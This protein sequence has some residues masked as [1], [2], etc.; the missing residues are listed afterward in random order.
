MLSVRFRACL[1]SSAKSLNLSRKRYDLSD[2]WM[3]DDFFFRTMK[4]N[5]TRCNPNKIYYLTFLIGIDSKGIKDRSSFE[6]FSLQ[7]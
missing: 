1:K 5:M 7:S 3:L 4:I 6:T 2:D